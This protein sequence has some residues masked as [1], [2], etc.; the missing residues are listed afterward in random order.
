MALYTIPKG[1][2][3]YLL[4][5]T[6]S[7]HGISR[8]YALNGKMAMRP[9]GG[10]FQLKKTFALDSD[11]TSFICMDFPL[12]GK[13]PQLTDIRVSAIS[14]GKAGGVNTTFEI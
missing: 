12:P 10:V 1:K 2:T 7:L 5:G 9:F 6:N 13:M 8:D 3:G 4:K 14:I 11:G